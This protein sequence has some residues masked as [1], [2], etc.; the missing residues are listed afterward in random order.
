MAKC[1]GCGSD[2]GAKSIP[3]FVH[4]SD[5]TRMERANKRWFIAF[6]VTLILLVGSNIG[7]MAYESSFE[8]VETTRVE[9]DCDGGTN[10]YIGNDGDINNG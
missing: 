6:L 4:E 7:W 9:Q 1:T 5:M 8:D 2:E 3:F 10:N